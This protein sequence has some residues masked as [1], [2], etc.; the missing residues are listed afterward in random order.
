M[1]CFQGPLWGDGWIR[2][3]REKRLKKKFLSVYISVSDK[4]QAFWLNH[5]VLLEI[6]LF[7]FQMTLILFS[8][9]MCFIFRS[10]Q[11]YLLVHMFVYY[12]QKGLPLEVNLLQF[13]FAYIRHTASSS[14]LLD[15]WQ[16]LLGLIRE[17]LQ[18][19]L[20]PP[21]LFLLLQ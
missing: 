10:Y 18:M 3:G 11:C 17:C 2:I 21:A 12:Q 5:S 4:V 1:A 16:S 6:Q 7:C 9:Q 14:Q 15:S 13:F 20:S 8:N 19:N